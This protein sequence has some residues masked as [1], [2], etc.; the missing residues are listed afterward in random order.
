MFIYSK[1]SAS[2]AGSAPTSDDVGVTG[3]GGVLT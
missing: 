3:Q 1:D 2:W